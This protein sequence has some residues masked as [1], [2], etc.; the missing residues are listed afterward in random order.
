MNGTS[1]QR[2]RNLDHDEPSASPSS[3]GTSGGDGGTVLH[4]DPEELRPTTVTLRSERDPDGPDMERDL[5][6]EFQF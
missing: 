3:G 6:G 2:Q 4:V 1:E 5:G